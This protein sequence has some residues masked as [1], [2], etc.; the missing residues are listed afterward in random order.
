LLFEFLIDKTYFESRFKS[1][2]E[3]AS[4][5]NAVKFALGNIYV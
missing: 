4:K 5:L 3:S 1:F 2:V